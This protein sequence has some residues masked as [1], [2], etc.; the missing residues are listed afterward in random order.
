[1]ASGFPQPPDLVAK[2]IKGALERRDQV[3]GILE[4]ARNAHKPIGDANLEA[5]L[6]EHKQENLEV[7][8]LRKLD[9]LT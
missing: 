5:V 6:R 2:R 7:T 1:M 9:F 8:Y 3:L 4:T